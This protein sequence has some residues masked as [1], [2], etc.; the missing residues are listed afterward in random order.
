MKLYLVNGVNWGYDEYDSFIVRAEN[1]DQARQIARHEAYGAGVDYEYYNSIREADHQ[2]WAK[3]SVQ[4]IPTDGEAG[5][6]LG[7]FNAG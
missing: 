4:E 1:E 6:I 3:A 2:G 7:S 5:I